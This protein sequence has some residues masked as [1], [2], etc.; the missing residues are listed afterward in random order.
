MQIFERGGAATPSR[1]ANYKIFSLTSAHSGFIDANTTRTY[2]L[3]RSKRDTVLRRLYEVLEG[4]FEEP[5]FA[6]QIL[7]HHRIISLFKEAQN[8]RGLVLAH[9]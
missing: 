3:Q 1:R 6:L 7:D 5:V 8:F 9:L 4:Y 2:K